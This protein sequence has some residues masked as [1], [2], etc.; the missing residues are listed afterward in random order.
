METLT[1][2]ILAE[3]VDE[4]LDIA[5]EAAATFP[6]EMVIKVERCT[7][8]D[9]DYDYEHHQILDMDAVRIDDEDNSVDSD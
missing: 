3:N 7:I 5:Y 6:T 9:R 8:T 1:I 2:D 4:A